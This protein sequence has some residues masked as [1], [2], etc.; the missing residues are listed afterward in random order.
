MCKCIWVKFI[1]CKA[2]ACDGQTKHRGSVNQLDSCV[3]LQNVQ[4]RPYATQ[5][6]CMCCSNQTQQ[7]ISTR[8]VHVT[9]NQC[10]QDHCVNRVKQLMH[11][12]GEH[13]WS[14]ENCATTCVSND[15][16]PRNQ[17]VWFRNERMWNKNRMC[18]SHQL[19]QTLACVGQTIHSRWS[20]WNH[21]EF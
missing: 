14:A 10:E 11:W 1:N 13:E 17:T 20:S 15:W 16:H 7:E 4:D 12:W 3:Q 8:H 19:F 21:Q 2:H 5:S 9:P 6:F 18:E